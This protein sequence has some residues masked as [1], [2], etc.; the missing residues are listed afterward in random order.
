MIPDINN[1]N[2]IIIKGIGYTCIISGVSKSDAIHLLGNSTSDN[3]GN[4]Y[5]AYQINPYKKESTTITFQL[6]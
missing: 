3:H 5:N 6:F 1:I 4:I 2:I